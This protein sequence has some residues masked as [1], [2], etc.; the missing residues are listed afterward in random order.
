MP[1]F[2]SFHRFFCF[3]SRREAGESDRAFAS[4]TESHAWRTNDICFVKKS[5]EEIPRAC[6]IRNFHPNVGRIHS[7]LYLETHLGKRVPYYLGI[8]HIVFDQ[9][10]P[11]CHSLLRIERACR[12]QRQIRYAAEH[13]DLAALPYSVQRHLFSFQRIGD[14][15][16][17]YHHKGEIR[18][19]K[20]G[21]L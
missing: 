4:R 13:R 8:S 5:L 17:R 19:R 10:L 9:F 15:F 6:I 21:S 12:T 3:L 20:T 18:S 2:Y 7:T 14:Q 1:L 16:F 11:L